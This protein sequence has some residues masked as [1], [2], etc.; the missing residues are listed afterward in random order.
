ME[1]V[2]NLSAV[3]HE[4]HDETVSYQ[5]ARQTVPP[6]G[7]RMRMVE[8]IPAVLALGLPPTR[9]AID[10]LVWAD[11]PTA[12]TSATVEVFDVTGRR[13]RT[14]LDGGLPAGRLE[15]SWDGS[16]DHGVTVPTGMYFVRLRAG[17]ETRTTR[18]LRIR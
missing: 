2:G 3:E 7:A 14:L 10:M 6:Q 5:P 4:V 13:V 18:I 1:L 11:F 16:D 9:L 8:E 17:K 12:H 15:V